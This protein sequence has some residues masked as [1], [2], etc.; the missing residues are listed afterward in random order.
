MRAA[1]I[2]ALILCAGSAAAGEV[3]KSQSFPSDALGRELAYTVYLP[4]GYA[5]ADARYPVLYLLHGHG[6]AENDWVAA[7]RLADTADRLIG[8]GAIAPMLIV[9]PAGGRDSWYVDNPDPG[10]AGLYATAL[11]RDLVNHVDGSYRTVPA[12]QR[13]AIAGLSMGGY[14]ALRLAFFHPDLYAAAAGLSPAVFEDLTGVREVTDTQ[15]KLFGP[16]YGDPFDPDR[17]NAANVFGRVPALAE[18]GDP[19]AVF[20]SVGDD[21]YF[22]LERGTMLLYLALKDAGVPAEVRVYD[23]AHDWRFWSRHVGEALRFVDGVFR[24]HDGD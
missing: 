7:G 11:T 15:L 22:G 23:G 12:R 16:A 13:R 18:H 21:D 20:L 14:G 17:F 9:M 6:G 3:R 24:R 4:D 2:A 1:L 8:D 5:E 19:P 10:G